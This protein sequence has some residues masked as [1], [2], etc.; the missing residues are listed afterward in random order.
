MPANSFETN[1]CSE[2]PLKASVTLLEATLKIFFSSIQIKVVLLQSISKG[3]QRGVI[4]VLARENVGN[5]HRICRDSVAVRVYSVGCLSN[6]A[7]S[8][9]FLRPSREELYI[10][11][12]LCYLVFVEVRTRIKKV[13]PDDVLGLLL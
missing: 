5:F 9:F 1:H 7:Y 4:L 6:S 12:T 3:N 10:S 8:R 11:T 2:Q 13:A